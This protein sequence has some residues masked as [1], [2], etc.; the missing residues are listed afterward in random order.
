MG[1]GIYIYGVIEAKE[2]KEF[3]PIGVGEKPVY[4]IGIGT[5]AF[6]VSEADREEYIADSV[7][8]GEHE[9]VLEV[10]MKMMTILPM[11][12]GT[13]AANEKEIMLM[14]KKHHHVFARALKKLYGKDSL[15]LDKPNTEFLERIKNIRGEI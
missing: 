8:L 10:V 9:R 2:L 1:S 4:T 5:L 12:F 15:S 11:R 6:V 7:N 14:L 13:V 3:G